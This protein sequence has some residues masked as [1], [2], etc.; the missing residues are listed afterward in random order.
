MFR[1]L[2]SV[3]IPMITV[4]R[5][6]DFIDQLSAGS[7]ADVKDHMQKEEFGANL[8]G[9]CG[10]MFQGCLTEMLPATFNA[11]ER[12]AV[13]QAPRSTKHL[14]EGRD[15][16][17]SIVGADAVLYILACFGAAINYLTYVSLVTAS[18]C[19]LT[20][21]CPFAEQFCPDGAKCL[22]FGPIVGLSN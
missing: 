16:S 1:L 3:A 21:I 17:V 6:T 10:A 5:L 22:Q 13:R 7:K 8:E 18:G 9:E 11:P 14:T 15:V 19:L 20:S 4:A 2:H 12:T